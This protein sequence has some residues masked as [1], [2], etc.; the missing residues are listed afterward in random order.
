M[1]AARHYVRP[2]D[3]YISGL[4]FQD[5]LRKKLRICALQPRCPPTFLR[6]PRCPP[7]CLR[8]PRCPPTFLRYPR[9]PPT[10]LR[11][12]RC[13]PTCLRYPRPHHKF[14]GC[15][16]GSGSLHFAAVLKFSISCC[17]G[18]T[19]SIRSTTSSST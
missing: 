9:C 15:C 14:A 4:V 16:S 3:G 13:P 8:Y 12:P 18:A 6:Y 19:I 10:F 5:V 1:A 7:T 17:T 11:Y 2:F